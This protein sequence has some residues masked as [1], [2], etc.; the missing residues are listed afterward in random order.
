MS[1]YDVDV[2]VYW[3]TGIHANISIL[4]INTSVAIKS[5]CQYVRERESREEPKEIGGS[6]VLERSEGKKLLASSCEFET[7]CFFSA[8]IHKVLLL[9]KLLVLYNAI[10]SDSNVILP[11]FQ[12][13]K[14]FVLVSRIL[15]Q[16][17]GV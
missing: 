7:I 16:I 6:I 4:I 12:E 15:R 10:P 11:L 8:H 13:K 17:F 2:P 9:N 3:L 14:K 1:N 5:C